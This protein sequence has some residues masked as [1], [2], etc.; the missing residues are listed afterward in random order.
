M[1]IV[2]FNQDWHGY[3]KGETYDLGGG[4]ADIYV[5]QGRAEYVTTTSEDDKVPGH[6]LRPVVTRDVPGPR[7][8]RRSNR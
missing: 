2:K 8:P 7:D 4:I 1:A 6:A 3:R 5:T